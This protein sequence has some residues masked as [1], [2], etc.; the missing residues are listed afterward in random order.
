MVM[1]T[2]QLTLNLKQQYAN[3][4]EMDSYEIEPILD[5]PITRTDTVIWMDIFFMKFY[6]TRK[7][8]FYPK[9]IRWK[10]K[11]GNFSMRFEPIIDVE[12]SRNEIIHFEDEMAA[13][14]YIHTKID[15]ERRIIKIMKEEKVTIEPEIWFF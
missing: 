2:T 1:S 14:R 9:I 8:R 5:E 7:V 6:T 12:R 3:E 10:D 13:F 4:L 15:N 11:Y